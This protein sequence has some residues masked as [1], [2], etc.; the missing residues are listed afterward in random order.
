MPYNNYVHVFLYIGREETFAEKL[1]SILAQLEFK[2]LVKQ[3]TEKGVNFTDHLY[4]P[5]VH[6]VTG[7][8]FCEM[9]DEGH[10]FKVHVI[11]V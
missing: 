9:E 4:V 3:W 10:V 1:R 5:E 11:S 2:M 6:P 8:V 7:K